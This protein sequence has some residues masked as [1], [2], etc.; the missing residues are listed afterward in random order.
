MK[1]PMKQHTLASS[2]VF[3]GVGLH[4]GKP[5]EMRLL[6]APDDYG[7]VF[8]RTD[9]GEEAFVHASVANV[10]KARRSTELAQQGV[11]VRTAEHLLAALRCL[12]VDN[13]LVQLNAMEVPI[14]D[15]SALPYVQALRECGLLEQKTDRRYLSV[16]RHAEFRDAK[17]GSSIIVDPCDD[18]VVD[19]TID[20]KSPMVGVQKAVYDPS[21]DFAS[22]IAPC[23]TFCFHREI[24]LLRLL[25]LIKGGSLDNALVI[26]DRKKVFLGGK[27]LYFDNELARHK[28]LDLLGDFALAGFPIRGRITA[29]KPG[30]KTN[31]QALNHFI[32]ESIL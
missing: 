5:V 2:C 26:D 14:L 29:Y 20:F 23:R 32:C 10:S 17:S 12:H 8:H 28:L 30:H 9:L 22:Q 31:T 15:G 4:T 19:L 25:G 3:T 27:K 24:L 1:S 11:Q 6:P 13:A 16:K 7:I 18:L 21:V